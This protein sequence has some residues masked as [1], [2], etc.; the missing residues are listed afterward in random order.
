MVLHL[1]TPTPASWTE[2][3]LEDVPGLLADHAHCELKAAQSALALV[4]RFGGEAPE[5]IE[6][7][8]ELARE[9]TAHFRQVNERLEARDAQ[10]GKPEVDEYVRDLTKAAREDHREWPIMM[11]KLIVAALIEARSCERFK[12]LADTLENKQSEEL[13]KL[14]Q[15]YRALMMAEAR[16]FALFRGLAENEYGL[17]A[18]SRLQSLAKR[19]AEVAGKLPLGPKVHG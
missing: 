7:L 6:P 4:A 1:L 5:I 19:E 12:L 18:R 2:A 10:L 14:G 9:E 11:D 8:A 15:F 3:A 16:H 17:L 13:Q